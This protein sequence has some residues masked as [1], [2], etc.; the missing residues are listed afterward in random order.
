MNQWFLSICHL[1]YQA[2][3]LHTAALWRRQRR[4]KT[5]RWQRRGRRRPGLDSWSWS[6]PD[7]SDDEKC[8]W[9]LWE[10]EGE[11][12]RTEFDHVP[13]ACDRNY[14]GDEVG[15]SSQ[16]CTVHC[17]LYTQTERRLLYHLSEKKTKKTQAL[18]CF[19]FSF[20][21]THIWPTS[22][23]LAE[24]QGL[25]RLISDQTQNF[26]IFGL[27]LCVVLCWQAWECLVVFYTMCKW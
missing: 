16:I 17:T 5:R 14:E 18:F 25:I 9:R 1:D 11:A 12:K 19:F 7:V 21:P 2:G 23:C 4:R 6:R 26:H 3:R 15:G 13:I 22:I 24:V 10:D 20:C 27:F 8:W